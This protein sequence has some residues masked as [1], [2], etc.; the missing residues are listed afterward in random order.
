MRLDHLLSRE[1][2]ASR[3]EKKTEED[4]R[5]VGQSETARL[6]VTALGAVPCAPR[7]VRLPGLRPGRTLRA[8]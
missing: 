3:E 2:K 7:S 4:G 5:P 1:N 6:R 8:A